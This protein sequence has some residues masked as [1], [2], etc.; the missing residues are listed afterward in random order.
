MKAMDA[1]CIETRQRRRLGDRRRAHRQQHERHRRAQH[2]RDSAHPA[3][4]RWAP[5]SVCTRVVFLFH[6]PLPGRCSERTNAGHRSNSLAGSVG[7]AAT[8]A[9]RHQGTVLG[10]AGT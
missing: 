2:A 4:W 1:L 7:S 3:L 9:N 10:S 8:S 5:R 6:C